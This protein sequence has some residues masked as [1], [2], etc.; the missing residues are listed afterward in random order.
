[1]LSIFSSPYSYGQEDNNEVSKAEKV[2]NLMTRE[3]ED[4]SILKEGGFSVYYKKDTI[5][6]SCD[7]RIENGQLKSTCEG[8]SSIE[9]KLKFSS[10]KSF[11]Y[12]GWY[13][14]D[15]K[16]TMDFPEDI[17]VEKTEKK[18]GWILYPSIQVT[19]FYEKYTHDDQEGKYTYF[20]KEKQ[21]DRILYSFKDETNKLHPSKWDRMY[22]REETI[23][24]TYNSYYLN[25]K[26]EL[27]RSMKSCVLRT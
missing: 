19:K 17:P 16:Y 3:V 9:D 5:E 11:R 7:A 18:K 12:S 13:E 25:G 4:V 21:D 6:V 23:T 1:M 26:K 20:H 14:G 27:K 15:M 2:K 22:D 10:R 24:G 8:Y